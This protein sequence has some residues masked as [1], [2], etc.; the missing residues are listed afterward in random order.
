M[1]NAQACI[2]LA[3]LAVLHPAA[4]E[5]QQSPAKSPP[6]PPP[7]VRSPAKESFWERVLRFS[8]V[9]ANPSSLKGGGDEPA[10]GQVWIAEL[11]TGERRKLTAAAGYRSPIFYPNGQDILAVQGDNAVRILASGAV[12]SQARVPGVV[13]LVG[14]NV[15]APE[16][17]LLLQASPQAAAVPA[18]L[19]L[20]DGSVTPI[21]YD[22]QSNRDRQMIEHLRDWQRVYGNSS[23]YIKR[24]SRETRIGTIDV[25]NV[26]WKIPSADP[27][28]VS[29]CEAVSCGQPALSADGKRAV[30]VMAV[31]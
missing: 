25:T 11:S 13:K 23:I 7:P 2:P 9:S 6:P 30:F 28:N 16:E 19:S 5:A 29:G 17:V 22:P 3:I 27:Q 26:F 20:R 14:F 4:L 24:E 1:R 18:R 8:G 21:P 12:T 10:S 31:R 15:D